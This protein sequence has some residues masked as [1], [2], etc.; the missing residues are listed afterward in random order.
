MMF[1]L[2]SF[3]LIGLTGCGDGDTA[4]PPAATLTR[5]NAAGPEAIQI[6]IARVSQEEVVEPV[7]GTGTMLPARTSNIGLTVEGIV[8]EIFVRVGDRV[9]KGDPLFRTRQTDLLISKMELEAALKLADAEADQ[10]ARDLKR[11]KNLQKKGVAS[12][13]R[14]DEMR[15]KN[16]IASARRDMARASLDGLEQKLRD[17]TVGAPYKSVITQRHVNEGVFLSNRMSGFGNSAVV[18]VQQID[19]IVARVFVP[20]KYLSKFKVG[21]KARLYIDGFPEPF[22]SVV[23]IVN[24]WIDVDSRA[25]DVRIGYKND[26]YKIKPGLFVRAEILPEPRTLVLLE[27]R[28]IRGSMGAPYVFVNSN[29]VAARRD[30]E[31]VD[32]D[33]KHFEVAKGLSQGEEVLLGPNLPQIRDGSPLLIEK[34]HVAR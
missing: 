5:L 7:I 30:V 25:I 34:A 23:H 20:E 8:E 31:I 6:S 13:A 22:E 16:E 4:E 2:L 11:T 18:E 9:E 24:D 3:V 14:L 10:A 27:R 26:D 19:I 17:T 12:T 32:Y 1:A 15:A 21:S 28:A 29:S 33:A